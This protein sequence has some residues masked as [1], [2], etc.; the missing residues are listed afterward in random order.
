[1]KPV[2][3]L[4]T[5]LVALPAYAADETY[6]SKL[7]TLA[8]NSKECVS[9]RGAA[10]DML[11]QLGADG[12]G[13]HV[14]DAVHCLEQVLE[15]P[16]TEESQGGAF[17]KLQAAVA[18]QNIGPAAQDSLAA[19]SGAVG[20]DR[21]L[22]KAI[23][24]AAEKITPP[25][26]ASATTGSDGS[27]LSQV[28]IALGSKNALERLLAVKQAEN[29]ADVILDSVANLISTDPDRDVRHEAA[30]ITKRLIDKNNK[31][32]DVLRSLYVD[33]LVKLLTNKVDGDISNDDERL[34]E[35]IFAAASLAAIKK[36]KAQF[37]ISWTT[38]F[39]EL[40]I[41]AQDANEDPLVQAIAKAATASDK[42][43]DSDDETATD[44]KTGSAPAGGKTGGKTGDG[45]A[46][47]GKS[48]DGKS[49]APKSPSG[50]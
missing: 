15:N 49:S 17:L 31:G 44:G 36:N 40:N 5:V 50:T 25:P 28:T 34:Q 3:L 4:L 46:A 47:G 30:I 27:T 20:D 32:D 23:Y 8:L 9:Q 37:R 11:G 18:L 39:G 43:D 6:V 12:L 16:K 33:K 13:T 14:D 26:A 1:M 38:A 29:Q 2:C 19:L 7:T 22:N 45:K 24:T 42:S 35:R 41:L 21:F 10:I 48:G